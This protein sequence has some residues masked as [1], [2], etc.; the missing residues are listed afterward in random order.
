MAVTLEQLKQLRLDTGVSMM[1]CKKALEETNGDSE[2]AIA[3]LRKAGAAKAAS[4]SDRSTGNGV[5]AS[6]IHSNNT[7]GVLVHLGCETDF[8]AKNDDFKVL[9]RDIA[10]HVA[11]SNPLYLSP[12]EVPA[13][14][15]E[16]EKDIWKELLKKEGKP[17]EMFGKIMIG[18]EKK[19]REELALST[20]PYIK[21][22]DITVGQLL[23]DSITKIGENIKVIKFIRFSV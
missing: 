13:E 21:N 1:A 10:M 12:E 7:L 15:L 16:K 4:R 19:F 3:I 23:T 5:I 9:G 20:Q 11:A 22:P 6:Y 17:E 14:L 18:K 8:V 2:K